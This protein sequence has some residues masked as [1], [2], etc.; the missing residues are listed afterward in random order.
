[1]SL[2]AR[3]C[4]LTLEPD[5]TTRPAT[6]AALW[7]G[8]LVPF[9]FASYGL[10]NWLAA[11][12]TDVGSIVFAWERHIP[13][14][15]WT[16][17]PY[18]SI[19]A[20]YGLSLFFCR[21]GKEVDRVAKRLLSAQVVAVACFIL[22]PLA[23]TSERPE[24]TGWAG[25]LFALLES[26]DGQHNMT[27]SL[28][29]ALLVILWTLYA[30]HVPRRWAWALHAWCALIGVSVLT[31]WQHH[32]I[33]V[34]RRLAGVVLRL[35]LARERP[36]TPCRLARRTRRAG[37]ASRCF[38]CLGCVRRGGQR[39][40]HRRLGTVAA[41]AFGIAVAG[42]GSLWW[43]RHIGLPEGCRRTHERGGAM[44]ARPLPDRCLDQFAPV[45]AP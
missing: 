38:L 19:D 5:M 26:F 20:L 9:F 31:T 27:P 45:D 15:A 29:I 37:L 3:D 7:T 36:V 25:P 40:R 1:M 11:Q 43:A 44:P 21:S 14:L 12:C 18:W 41:L 8:F 6:R 16:I 35:A 28:H 4:P 2:S 23:L 33:D 22:F 17:V 32:F 39:F 10:A 24:I 13:F 30:K 34:P 42:R